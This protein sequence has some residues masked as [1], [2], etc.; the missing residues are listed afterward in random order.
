MGCEYKEKRKEALKRKEKEPSQNENRVI[1]PFDY[2]PSLPK[3]D[4]ILKKHHKAL[5]FTNPELKNIFKNPPMVAYRQP[6]NIRK[7]LCKSSLTKMKNI[8]KRPTRGTHTNTAG[9]RKCSKPCP[10]C[11][12][13]LPNSKQVTAQVTGYTHQI[14]D[15]VNCQTE[16]CIYYWK[17]TKENCPDYPKC[18]YVGKTKRKF[19]IRFSEHRD[20]AKNMKLSEPSGDHFNKPGHSVHNLKGM[21]LEKVKSHD[22]FV[23]RIRESRLIKLFDTFNYGLNKC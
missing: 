21:V 17:C 9:W 13:T 15:S 14:V 12:M 6:P 11:P 1:A 22:P 8:S 16:N 3:I 18:E 20:Y 23:L 7:L 5:L 2:N 10:I 19:Q 4:N